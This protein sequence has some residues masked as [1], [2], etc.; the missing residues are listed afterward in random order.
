[1]DTPSTGSAGRDLARRVGRS[2]GPYTRRGRG[3][4]LRGPCV[5]AHDVR[6]DHR[7]RG[8]LG[9]TGRGGGRRPHATF[10][11]PSFRPTGPQRATRRESVNIDCTG[12]VPTT[13]PTCSSRPVSW[14]PST[15]PPRLCSPGKATSLPGL[16]AMITATPEL[17]PLSVAFPDVEL[18]W[19]PGHQ[20][21]GADEPTSRPQRHLP[22]HGRGARLGADRLCRGHDRPRDL[23]AGGGGDH[24]PQLEG[25][26]ALP[27]DQS[28][29]GAL[30]DDAPRRDSTSRSVH[31]RAPRP[32][33][34]WPRWS[35][36]RPTWA[37]V[38]A[39]PG[40]SPSS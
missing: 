29:R 14:W 10:P 8:H 6:G 1:M 4:R 38:A 39:V 2:E 28:H 11:S 26:P 9:R 20:L 35:I 7:R 30:D 17:N 18:E 19:G 16:L 31:A 21:H 33:G 13:I 34:G 23:Q 37:G 25:G 12:I 22:A 32:T 24:G 5:T 27:G 3:A 40:R 15:P 36:S